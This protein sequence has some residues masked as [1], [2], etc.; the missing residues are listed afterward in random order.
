MRVGLAIILLCLC[1]NA[2]AQV[3]TYTDSNGNRAYTDQPR[4]GAK[5]VSISTTPAISVPKSAASPAPVKPPG[6]RQ[7]PRI[8]HY[9]LLRIL[10]PA[11]EGTVSHAGGEVV[12]TL[13]SEP[14]LVPGDL[15][16]LLLDDNPVGA[17]GTSPVIP[18]TNVDRGEH[19]LAVRIID[20]HGRVVEQ[21]A[22]QTFF[23]QRISLSQ[24]RRMKPCQKGDYGLRP[25]C[26][27]SMKPADD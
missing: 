2:T 27:T 10:S 14:A 18:L 11:P 12:V 6:R 20:I 15:F 9:D 24:K 22:S 7:P 23:M 5:P 1:T 17:P 21:T 26:P 4:P 8:V 25:E 16:E 19:R 3:Y 13:T